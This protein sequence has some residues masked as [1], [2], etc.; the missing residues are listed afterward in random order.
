MS[1]KSRNWPVRK[2]VEIFE[3]AEA[4]NLVQNHHTHRFVVGQDNHAGL[5]SLHHSFK[6]FRDSGILKTVKTTR[7][8]RI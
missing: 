2:V 7:E 4:R 8:V 1:K 5:Y 6:A 3:T